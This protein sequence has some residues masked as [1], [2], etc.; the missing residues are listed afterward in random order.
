MQNLILNTFKKYKSF[1]DNNIGNGEGL[2]VPVFFGIN[3]VYYSTGKGEILDKV[4]FV[5]G[6]GGAR[7]PYLNADTQKLDVLKENT[8]KSG[9]RQ[10]S[11]LPPYE[12]IKRMEKFTLEVL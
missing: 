9:R 10:R 2:S 6:A 7:P 1:L 3:R 11:A 5:T 12:K 8:G 4:N